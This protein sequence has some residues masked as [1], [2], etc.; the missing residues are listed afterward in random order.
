MSRLPA[1]AKINIAL[2][3][4]PRRADGLHELATVMQRVDICDGV[5]VKRAAEC[6]VEGFREDTIVRAALERLASEAAV[7]DGWRVR[8]RKQ[9]PVAA[10]LGG[11][12]ADAA[13]A[14]VLANAMLGEPP[15]AGA[16]ARPRRRGRRR[17]VVLSRAR[18]EARGGLRRAAD[19]AR[20]PP[21]FLGA[22]RPASHCA[23]GLDR[24]RLSTLRRPRGQRGLRGAAGDAA[25]SACGRAPPA[26]LCRVPSER[27][28]NRSSREQPGPPVRARRA[29]S[30]RTSAARGPPFTPCSI[31]S[32]TPVRQQARRAAPGPDLGRRPRLVTS[33]S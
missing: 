31:G 33:L 11:G 12:S 1:A 29:L 10:G 18:P 25:R 32:R 9:I 2:V 20:A 13:A 21:G 4:G 19:P 7:E 23:E 15:L 22:H 6:S 24:G 17:R 16:L 28:C 3:V 30:E 27:P 5:E 26:R 8:L 14:L